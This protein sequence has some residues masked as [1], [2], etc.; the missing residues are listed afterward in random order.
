MRTYHRV[1]IVGEA[2]PEDRPV[3]V[4]QNHTNGLCDAHVLMCTTPRPLR[5]LVKYK[6]ITA[7][8][9]GWMLRRMRAV[10]VYRRKD[11]VDTRKNA[12]SFEAIDEALRESSVV[13]LFPEGESLNSIGLRPLKTGVARMATSAEKSVPGGLGVQ[14]V[15]IGVTYEDRDRLRCIASTV[16]GPPINAADHLGSDEGSRDAIQSLLEAVSEGIKNLI[17]HADSQEEYDTAV[18]LERL[19]PQGDAPIGMRRKRAQASL[20]ADAS[21]Q[22][23]ERAKAIRAL[24]E[25]FAAARLTGDD[26]LAPAA[27]AAAAYAP[28]LTA[29]PLLLFALPFWL[30]IAGLGVF[31]SKFPKT[32]DKKVTLRVLFGYLALVLTIPMWAAVFAWLASGTGVSSW[33]GAG[34]GLGLYWL[35]AQVFVPALDRWIHGRVLRARRALDANREELASLEA[36]LRSIREAYAQGAS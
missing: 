11:G 17:L 21:P 7:P 22:A 18:A 6:L 32:P 36:S 14:V 20:R 3:L 2:F 35:A 25:R 5:I 8:V 1:E 33:V 24:G 29:L 9:I 10:P 12:Q 15:P 16:I 34:V 31:I 19:L 4:V 26:V 13:A 23:V 30:P 28:L 27:S